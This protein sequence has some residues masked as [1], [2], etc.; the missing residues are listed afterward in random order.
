M[1]IIRIILAVTSGFMLLWFIITFFRNI[2][3]VGNIAGTAICGCVFIRC[4]FNSYFIHLK[5]ICLNRTFTKFI[6]RFAQTGIIAFAVYA[7]ICTAFMIYFSS[8]T[9]D[10]KSTVITLGALV[11]KDNTPSASLMGRINGTYEYLIENPDAK[12]VLSGGKG[13]NEGESEADC[14]YQEL[15][16]KGI[17]KDRLLIEDKSV[18]TESNMKNSY[19]II[20]ANDLPENIAISTDRYH[21]L[22]ARIIAKKQGID[23]GIGA[24]N[25][26]S[27]NGTF[28]IAPAFYVREWFAIPVELL[29]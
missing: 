28:F 5:E 17:D 10:E 2:L 15:I 13:D 9:P 8:V 25:A 24:V 6:W 29:K 16:K 7:V 11:H 23:S 21:Q 4:V 20:K 14:M 12:A 18:N 3:N 19:E 1:N 26:K 27:T 22:R